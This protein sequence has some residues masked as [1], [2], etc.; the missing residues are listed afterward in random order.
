MSTFPLS[1]WENVG[2]Y[3]YLKNQRMRASNLKLILI[4]ST[5]DCTTFNNFLPI[6]KKKK[7]FKSWQVYDCLAKWWIMSGDMDLRRSKVYRRSNVGLVFIFGTIVCHLCVI[8][9]FI[10]LLT[11]DNLCKPTPVKQVVIAATVILSNMFVLELYICVW[12][13][14]SFYLKHQALLFL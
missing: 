4:S 7:T 8:G 1:S 11:H 10:V 5:W 9:A 2:D 13:P 12:I 3:L 6:F 14:L